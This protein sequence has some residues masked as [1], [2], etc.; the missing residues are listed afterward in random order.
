MTRSGK[1]PGTCKS[2]GESI[3]RSALSEGSWGF[4]GN[5]GAGAGQN[6]KKL[7][8]LYPSV[9]FQINISN[10]QTKW[11]KIKGYSESSVTSAVSE[12]SWLSARSKEVTTRITQ[13]Q[14]LL[15]AQKS[16]ALHPPTVLSQIPGADTW[17]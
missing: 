5:L 8:K 15:T 2:Q 1:E 14:C 16:F 10:G 11:S 7:W 13:K 12:G 9:L 6:N 3:S 17:G 4:L